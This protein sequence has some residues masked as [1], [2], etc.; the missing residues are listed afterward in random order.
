MHESG[1]MLLALYANGVLRLWNMLDARC[2]FKFKAGMSADPES[3]VDKES[4]EE[5]KEEKKD[6]TAPKTDEV[7]KVLAVYA[8]R[9]NRAE[10]VRWEPTRGQ[11]YAV[12]FSR[13]LEIY[14]VSEDE[15]IHTMTFDTNQTSFTY[16]GH[17]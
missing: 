15:P 10:Q 6:V 12:L 11:Q 5:V 7:K 8:Q 16:M 1:R 3:E 13:V 14:S 2:L 4:E 9:N 17:S